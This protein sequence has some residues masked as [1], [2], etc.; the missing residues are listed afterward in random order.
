V[1]GAFDNSPANPANPAPEKR[2]RFGLQTWDE[3]FIG[4]FEA[5]DDPD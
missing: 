3:M 4:F 5:A 2:V 1:T